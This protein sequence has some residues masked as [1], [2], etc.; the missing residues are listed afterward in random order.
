MQ[1]CHF[2]YNATGLQTRISGFNKTDSRKKFPVRVLT[3]IA[4]NTFKKDVIKWSHFMK[5]TKLL[6]RVLTL[7]K[8]ICMHLTSYI[9]QEIFGKTPALKISEDFQ[10]NAYGKN[11]LTS[12]R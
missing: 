5:V 12:S 9:F 7:I 10:K 6:L 8:K 11:L 2:F 3:E 4:G 1:N